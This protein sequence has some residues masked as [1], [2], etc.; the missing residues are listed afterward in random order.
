MGTNLT[1]TWQSVDLPAYPAND[2]S[3]TFKGLIPLQPDGSTVYYY[4]D[5]TANSGKNTV[6]PLTAPNGA[7]KFCVTNTVSSKEAPAANLLDIYPNPAHAIT[8]IPVSSNVKTA[9]SIRVFN[10]LG[11]QISTLF[12]GEIPAGSSNY[13]LNADQYAA[14][15]YFVQ[16]QTSSQ[17][18]LKKLIVR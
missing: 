15:T 1:G 5:A 7:W 14:G 18:L 17:T 10:A 9:G 3:W 16:L 13:F 11:Q 12:D 6:H 4:I 8:C 2:T